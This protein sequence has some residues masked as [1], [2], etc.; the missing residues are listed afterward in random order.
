M[1]ENYIALLF[2]F[3][4]VIPDEQTQPFQNLIEIGNEFK[5]KNMELSQE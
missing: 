4:V 1:K 5:A 3:V 2:F